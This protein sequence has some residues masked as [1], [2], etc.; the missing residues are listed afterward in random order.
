MAEEVALEKQF[1]DLDENPGVEEQTIPPGI[2]PPELEEESTFQRVEDEPQTPQHEEK[3]KYFDKKFIILISALGSLALILLIVLILLI[4][5]KEDKKSV[6]N[7][8]VLDDNASTSI[9]KVKQSALDL[10]V[11]KAN[12][13]YEKGDVESALEL[14]NNINI[15]NQSLSSYNL[16]VAQMKQKDY[17]SAI[18][19]FKQ[20]LELEEHK[21]AAAINLAVCYFYLGDKTKFDY[22]IDLAKVY[23]PQ[24]SKSSLYDYYLGLINYYQGY[25][26]EALQMF[27]KVNSQSYKDKSYY[28]SGKIYSALQS[29]KYAIDFLSKQEEYDVNLPLGL[30]YARIGD[31]S[32]A[33]E[34]L[35]KSSKIDAHKT[36]SQV[37][38]SLV[39][40]KTGQYD[41]GAQ[42]LKA[43]YIKD[44]DIG[45]K[46]YNIKTRLKRNFSNIDIAQQ[47]FAKRLITGKQ[48]IYDLLFYFAP[49]RVFDIKQS[50][51][52]ITKADLGNFIQGYEYENELL[53]RSRALSGVNVELSNAINLAFNFHLREANQEFKNLSE[54]YHAHDVIHYNLALTYAQLQ[55][56]NNAYKHFSTAYHLN[57]KNYI[58]GIFAIFCMDLIKK[59]S[60]KLINEFLE[61]LQADSTIDQNNNIY[62]YLLYLSRNDY[63]SMI[64]YLDNLPNKKSTPLELM[65]TIIAA[66]GNSLDSLRNQKIKELKDLLSEDIISNILYFNS[67][68]MELDIKEYAKQA[69]IYFLNAKLDFNSLFGG[70]GIVKDSYVTL[71]QI[72][73]LLNHVRNDI[74]K[75]LATSSKNSIGLIFALAYIDIFAK[76]YQ[77][78]YTLYNILIDDYK[79]KDAQT[80]F[81]AA[82]AAIGSNN[83]NSAI[84]LLELARLENEE[85]LEAR[86]ALGLLYHEVQN[87]EPAIFQYEKVGNDFKSKFF[88]FDIK[89]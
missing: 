56:Y 11:Q 31:Y 63:T 20:S 18:E 87:I 26:P 36:R 59:D 9:T 83:P 7:T 23:L 52:L 33:K 15:F 41:S 16:G 40:L 35:E 71:M 21:V 8:Q 25:F 54:I 60:T 79:I 46:Y 78:A 48:Q 34:H 72:T 53:V 70:S 29:E 74:K 24:D 62:K 82:V 64:P 17:I 80:L 67:K 57:P 55:D 45:A 12:L 77:E 2:I 47:N 4:I 6:L 27:M 51:E 38:L 32:K 19:N 3:K 14:Y 39:E 73:G 22:Y 30:L 37:A 50:M 13:L 88:T 10:V 61:N 89:N 43:L 68:N 86:L 28:L 85:T 84:A 81:L 76:E 42:I 69:Q 49:Y 44:K 1:S 65:F 75:R 58:A 66:N 5:F